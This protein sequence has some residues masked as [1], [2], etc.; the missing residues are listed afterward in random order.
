MIG[1]LEN[2]QGHIIYHI[3]LSGFSVEKLAYT[4]LLF[5]PAAVGNKSLF[6]THLTLIIKKKKETGT[7][8]QLVT[9]VISDISEQ[10]LI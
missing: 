6:M 5:I 8:L 10:F 4:L 1:L 9:V 7:F 2:L 3:K